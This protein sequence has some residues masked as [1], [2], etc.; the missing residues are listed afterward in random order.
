MNQQGYSVFDPGFAS[1]SVQHLKATIPFPCFRWCHNSKAWTL[2]VNCVPSHGFW[3][4]QWWITQSDSVT[5][6]QLGTVATTHIEWSNHSS[7]SRTMFQ[8]VQ[9]YMINHLLSEVTMVCIW[10]QWNYRF[11][12]KTWWAILACVKSQVSVSSA[13]WHCK[14][15]A[16][17]RACQQ[18][19]SHTHT[20]SPPLKPCYSTHN[21]LLIYN[22]HV[23][24]F[25]CLFDILKFISAPSI[26]LTAK[27]KLLNMY[28]QSK[29]SDGVMGLLKIRGVERRSSC[30]AAAAALAVCSAVGRGWGRERERERELGEEGSALVGR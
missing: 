13:D 2:A 4:V 25:I 15:F 10:H 3:A 19:P 26:P 22:N 28:S 30:L 24:L 12:I 11:Q 17:K 6:V 18:F 29:H 16:C 23:F 7:D 27:M 5:K 21:L 8:A 20:H 14:L 1:D 9:K